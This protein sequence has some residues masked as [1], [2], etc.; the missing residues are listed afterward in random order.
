VENLP[1]LENITVHQILVLLH[2]LAVDAGG[3]AGR[4]VHDMSHNASSATSQQS[5][6]YFSTSISGYFRLTAANTVACSGFPLD[7]A[8][9]SRACAASSIG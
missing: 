7:R 9:A 1:R 2:V 8:S 6:S 3:F 4:L 5:T